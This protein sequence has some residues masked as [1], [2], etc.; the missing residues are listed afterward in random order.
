MN[1]D[2]QTWTTEQLL[3]ETEGSR[4]GPFEG[5][6]LLGWR[7]VPP[8]LSW[9]ALLDQMS[10]DE[11]RARLVID[12]KYLL[13]DEHVSQCSATA[14]ESFHASIILTPGHVIAADTPEGWKMTFQKRLA[15][16][17]EVERALRW[18][19]VVRPVAGEV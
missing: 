11:A 13:L 4:G 19:S 7:V 5:V 16:E 12:G 10:S 14:N 3:Q 17:A 2:R 8:P 9:K 6:A 18:R 1:I 15:T